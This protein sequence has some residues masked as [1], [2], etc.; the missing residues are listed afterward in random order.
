SG[1]RV[2]GSR[3]IGVSVRRAGRAGTT[4]LPVRTGLRRTIAAASTASETKV[5]PTYC[6]SAAGTA[7]ATSTDPCVAAVATVAAV[8]DVAAVAAGIRR[9]AGSAAR[10]TV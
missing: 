3:R 1:R 7:V 8:A 9:T 6:T 5:V 10:D 2:G 4:A